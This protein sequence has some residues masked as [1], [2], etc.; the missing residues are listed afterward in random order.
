MSSPLT[1]FQKQ[2]LARL[3]GRAYN[4]QAAIARGAGKVF[5][6]DAERWR[7]DQVAAACGKLGL[8]C[9]SQLDYKRVEAHFLELLGEHGRAFQAQVQAET[10]PRRQ[11]EAVLV[12]ECERAGLPLQYAEKIC[13]RQFRCSLF[14]AGEK[15]IWSLV[16]T[17]RNRARKKRGVKGVKGVNV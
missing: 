1:N 10:E 14:D 17:V 16:Y 6:P 12:R 7:H 11:A 4:L 8:R 2:H 5:E 9:C 15:Q 13:Q 3:A